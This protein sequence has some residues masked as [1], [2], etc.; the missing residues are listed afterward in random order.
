MHI[1][2]NQLVPELLLKVYDTFINNIDILSMCVKKCHAK[3]IF[4]VK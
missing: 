4:L 2:G 1:Q 3:K